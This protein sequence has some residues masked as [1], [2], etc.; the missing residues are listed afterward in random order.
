[1]SFREKA[2]QA[3]KDLEAAEAETRT[4]IANA[5]QA[6]AKLAGIKMQQNFSAQFGVDLAEVSFDT[7]PDRYGINLLPF[8]SV[9]GENFSETAPGEWM[10]VYE[11]SDRFH[12]YADG[13]PIRTM[14]DLGRIFRDGIVPY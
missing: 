1:M 4:A 11:H 14:A 5:E 3:A 12:L 7:K 8:V 6:K 2:I 10:P 9:E 13:D